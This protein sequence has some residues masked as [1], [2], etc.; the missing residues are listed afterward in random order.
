MALRQY[1]VKVHCCGSRWLIQV[2][3]IDRWTPVDEKKAIAHTAKTMIASVTGAPADSFGVDLHEDRVVSNIE[4]Y[5]AASDRLR[6]WDGIPMP[7]G[8]PDAA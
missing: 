5:A 6:R 2:P 3:A 8:P 4:E 1:L 7:A